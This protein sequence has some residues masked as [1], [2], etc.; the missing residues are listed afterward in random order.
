M[1]SISNILAAQKSFFKSQKT[2]DISFRLTLLKALKEEIISKEDAIYDA[3]NEDFKKS[4]FESFISEYGL[5]IS[6]VNLAIKNLKTWG[7]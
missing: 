7:S 5:V 4:K 3:L 1:N 2:K 6:E